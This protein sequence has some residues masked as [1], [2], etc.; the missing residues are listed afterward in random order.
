MDR[1][2]TPLELAQ[3]LSVPIATLYRWRY[4]DSGPRSV[5]V[6]RHV[7]YFASDVE[8]WLSAAPS[9]GGDS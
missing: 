2:L 8:E 1:L 6:G 5:R 3:L 4:L 9:R 7:R